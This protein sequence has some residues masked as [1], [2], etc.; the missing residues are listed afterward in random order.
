MA[1]LSKSNENIILG[2][3]AIIVGYMAW[4]AYKAAQKVKNIAGDAIDAGV[5]FVTEDLNPTSEYNV[6]NQTIGEPVNKTV[7]SVTGHGLG[8]S[9]FC[10][11]NSDAPPC[12][13]ELF[14]YAMRYNLPYYGDNGKSINED[15]RAR[16]EAWKTSTAELQL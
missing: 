12:N 3:G 10:L 7:E 5:D 16:F 9:L 2:V 15:T 13:E 14:S 6:I 8:G 1:L 11:F 4:Q